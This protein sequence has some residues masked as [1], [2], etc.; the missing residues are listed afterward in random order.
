MHV[1]YLWFNVVFIYLDILHRQVMQERPVDNH[2]DD[3]HDCSDLACNV[4]YSKGSTSCIY[5]CIILVVDQV[6]SRHDRNCDTPVGEVY[7]QHVRAKQHH[8][9][10]RYKQQQAESDYP[11]DL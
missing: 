4:D 10:H 11:Y 2:D 1:E 8:S 5:L 3:I 9:H 6:D 7:Y